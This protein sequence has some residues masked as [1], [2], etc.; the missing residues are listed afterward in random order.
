MKK[1]YLIVLAL[2][3]PFASFAQK[4]SVS[5]NIL[6][7]ADLGTI[8]AEV[9]FAPGRHITINLQG[10]YN[11][12][13]FGSVEKGNPFQDRVRGGALGI[14]WWPW[15]VFS[16]WWVGVNGRV[17]EYNRGGLFKKME[18]EEG[19]AIGGGLSVG[20]SL[21]LSKHWNIDFGVGG[22]CGQTKYT[23]YACPRCG[24]VIDSG[25]KFFIWP[26]AN[27]QVSFVYIF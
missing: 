11:N 20:Y 9:G 3:M 23:T 4:F 12:W 10:E 18:T 21:M 26:S 25:K 7:W 24:S 8:N 22:W 17:E 2:I 13:N 6:D 16:G 27:T 15:N 5:T 19:F 14:R 1:V